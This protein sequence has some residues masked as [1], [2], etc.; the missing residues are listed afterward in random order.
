MTDTETRLRDYLHTTAATVRD[1]PPGLDLETD[2]TPHR[3]RWPVL[4]AAAAIAIVLV[5]AAS[6]LTRF[7]PDRSEP[8]GPPAPVSGEA[9]RIP[10]TVSEK[11]VTTLYDG[12]QKV[13]VTFPSDGYFRGRVGGGWLALK[14]PENRIL[15]AGILLPNGSFRTIPEAGHAPQLERPEAVAAELRAFLDERL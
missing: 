1:N 7:S 3:R 8:A 12:E 5:L 15:Q 4:L 11:R 10:Y 9:P 6:F 14:M 2:G 13:R